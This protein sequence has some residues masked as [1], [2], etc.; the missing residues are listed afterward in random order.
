MLDSV[1][2]YVYG[3]IVLLSV[4]CFAIVIWLGRSLSATNAPSPVENS[5]VK[6]SPVK[7]Q[8]NAKGESSEQ[9]HSR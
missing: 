8:H 2:P 4:V 7:K 1:M 9:P 5:P 3:S 6:N